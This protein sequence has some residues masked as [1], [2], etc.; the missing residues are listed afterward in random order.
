MDSE[1]L[2]QKIEAYLD[3]NWDL[4]VEDVT[5]LVRIESVEDI[6]TAC[7]GAPFG[8]GPREA[9]AAALEIAERMGFRTENLDGYIGIADFPGSTDDQLAIIGHT[10]VVPAGPGWTFEPF[11]VTRKD[12]YLMGRGTA[13]D[14][15]PLLVAMHAV[16]FWMDEGAEFPYTVRVLL[17]ANEETQMADV[18][19]Y[20]RQRPDPAFLITPDAEFPV[21]YG[22]KGVV[23]LLLSS[24]RIEDGRIVSIEGGT[25]VNAVPGFATATVRAETRECPEAAGIEVQPLKGAAD[26]GGVDGLMRI[27]AIGKSAHASTPELGVSAIGLLAGYILDNGLCSGDERDFLQLA[28]KCIEHTDGSGV[29]IACEDSDF[30][31]LTLACGIIDLRDGILSLTLDVRFPTAITVEGIEGRV[32]ELAGQIGATVEET[33]SKPTFICDP[34][35][36][37]VQAL[38]SA[39]NEATGEDAEPFTMGG[40]TYARMFARGASFGIEKPWVEAPDWVGSMHGPDEGVSEDALKEEFRIYVKTIEKLMRVDL[41]HNGPDP[42]AR[43]AGAGGPDDASGSAAPDGRA[44]A[45]GTQGACAPGVAASGDAM[46]SIAGLPATGGPWVCEGAMGTMLLQE[47]AAIGEN[48]AYLNLT[49]PGVVS[50]VHGLYRQAGSDCAITNSFTPS[51]TD[52]PEKLEL[53]LRAVTESVRMAR[54]AG[55]SYVMGDIGPSGAVLEPLGYETFEHQ[56]EIYRRHIAAL[57]EGGP[58]AILIES[59]IEAADMRCAILAAKEQTDI[60]IIVSCTFSEN[61]RMLLSSTSPAAAAVIA[62]HMGASIVGTNCGLAPDGIEKM[63]AEM[64]QATSLPLIAQP[65][66]GLPQPDEN[67]NSVYSGTAEELAPYVK[68]Y[69]DMG[70]AIVGSCCGSTPEFTSTIVSELEGCE[71]FS[72]RSIG[73]AIRLA[74]MSEMLASD[75]GE[76]DCSEGFVYDCSDGFDKWDVLENVSA[77]PFIVRYGNDL[78]SLEAALRI[79][80]GRAVA[81]IEHAD[82]EAVGLAAKY[83]AAVAVCTVYGA[84]AQAI[85]AAAAGEGLVAEDVLA[86]SGEASAADLPEGEGDLDGVLL[87]VWRA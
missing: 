41:G 21:C 61:G 8:E 10:D 71:P 11:D 62:E 37:A 44:D 83:G 43:Q 1:E 82:A 48:S 27:R 6:D 65:N 33:M 70:C 16:K 2:D 86:F 53:D 4:M 34:D 19:Y 42:K 76:L 66:A 36:P 67:G 26:D 59:C 32:S 78:A 5:R 20:L 35:S 73:P 55:Y 84:D 49:D 17:G 63:V 46:G 14:K 28:M 57:L 9:L 22:E 52:D 7:E 87:E 79:Y 29:G 50:K 85:A 12:G 30:G 80:P 13:D 56:Y 3:E 23:N 58:D 64:S 81:C 38:L 18:K 24:K 68:S 25:A 75:D 74:S 51:H 31:P 47:G 72:K 54:D 39:Y 15:A 69:V 77:V 60:P 45:W 40:G